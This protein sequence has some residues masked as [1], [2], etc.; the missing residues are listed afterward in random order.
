[1]ILAVATEPMDRG[2][3]SCPPELPPRDREPEAVGAERIEI[4]DFTNIVG[5]CS[6]GP[7]LPHQMLFDGL[8]IAGQRKLVR[9]HGEPKVKLASIK[10][11]VFP[12]AGLAELDV[13]HGTRVES[14][15][16]GYHG[17]GNRF[18]CGGSPVRSAM[19]SG[20]SE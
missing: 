12:G 16:I 15:H 7:A 19:R 17:S 18:L 6:G 20:N 10:R 4:K 8:S 9:D 1:M 13:T 14:F 3:R 5:G 2:V 11:D